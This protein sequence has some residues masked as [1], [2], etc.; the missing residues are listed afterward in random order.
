MKNKG[1][2]NTGQKTPV[3]V[4]PPLIP[5]PVSPEQ[6]TAMRLDDRKLYVVL[7]GSLPTLLAN[8]MFKENIRFYGVHTST[9]LKDMLMDENGIPAD[10]AIVEAHTLA[11]LPQ[12][13]FFSPTDDHE[14]TVM[15]TPDP[16][17][18][19]NIRLNEIYAVMD[20]LLLKKQL[21]IK[22][23]REQIQQYV[24]CKEGEVI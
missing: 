22:E 1:K 19:D 11:A 16:F 6:R 24:E 15:F 5:H 23:L 20:E 2:Q 18:G 17:I 12:M 13:S 7:C 21:W 10:L 14:C 8:L 3:F 9:K 4:S